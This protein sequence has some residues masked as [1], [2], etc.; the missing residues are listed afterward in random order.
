M[1]ITTTVM[2]IAQVMIVTWIAVTAPEDCPLKYMKTTDRGGVLEH[3][4]QIHNFCR[5]AYLPQGE[6][7]WVLKEELS[8]KK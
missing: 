3:H 8:E 2:F 7:Y 4:G 5:T 6:Y 1:I